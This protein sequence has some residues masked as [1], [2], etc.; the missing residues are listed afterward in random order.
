MLEWIT[1]LKYR[2]LH[3]SAPINNEKC[4]KK[5]SSNKSSSR[6]TEKIT[7]QK[8]SGVLIQIRN[9]YQQNEN[10]KK[11]ITDR[12]NFRVFFAK[13]LKKGFFSKS[14][15]TVV[16]YFVWKTQIWVSHTCLTSTRCFFEG[17]M[18]KRDYLASWLEK[19]NR[20]IFRKQI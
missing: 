5:L 14:N 15:I 7:N 8:D 2:I 9:L 11:I 4:S 1:V 6:I 17:D 3:W 16:E 13:P 20:L 18:R 10:S 19:K 12:T